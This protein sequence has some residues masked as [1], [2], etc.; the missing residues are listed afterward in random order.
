MSIDVLRTKRN[1]L[2][3]LRGR[4]ISF[5]RTDN[6]GSSAESLVLHLTPVSAMRSA[7]SG[8]TCCRLCSIYRNGRC[9][10]LLSRLVKK[11]TMV[12]RLSAAT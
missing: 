6:N 5:P 3:Q 2:N 9:T 12:L 7:H 1:D 11:G 8:N 10:Y 4:Y